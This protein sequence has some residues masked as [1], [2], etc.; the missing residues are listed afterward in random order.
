VCVCVFFFFTLSRVNLLCTRYVIFIAELV[1]LNNMLISYPCLTFI[2][3]YFSYVGIFSG[4]PKK[5]NFSSEKH[6]I[7][8]ITLENIG[9]RNCKNGFAFSQVIFTVR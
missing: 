6:I 9:L 1:L 2:C 3:K 7:G 4:F 5:K 8:H